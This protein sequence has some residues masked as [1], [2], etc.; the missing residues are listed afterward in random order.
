[1]SSLIN[2]LRDNGAMHTEH[3]HAMVECYPNRHI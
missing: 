2:N 3:T 1:M